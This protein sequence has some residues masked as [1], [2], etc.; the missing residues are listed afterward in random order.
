MANVKNTFLSAGVYT[1]EFDLSF[2]PDVIPAVGLAVVG[3]A[4]RGPGL[5]PTPV[6][7][8]SEYLRWF[9]DVF[10]SGS[11]DDKQE[12]K[13]LTTYAV[14]EYLRYGE[15]CTITRIMGNRF[16]PAKSY[17]LAQSGDSSSATAPAGQDKEDY[18]DDAI[19]Q[20]NAEET[21]TI[22]R[23]QY[24]SRLD[25]DPGNDAITEAEFKAINDIVDS[26]YNDA[27]DTA[28]NAVIPE[29]A[30]EL[31]TL[32]DGESSNS[33]TKVSAL[34]GQTSDYDAI[35]NPDG[36][37][38]DTD[39][40]RDGSRY[41]IRWEVANVD[42]K[43][44]TFDVYI[45]RGDDSSNRPIRLEAFTGVTLDPRQ[46]NYIEKVI[47]N[48]YYA[49][50]ADSSG[51]PYLQKVGTYANRSRFV[52]V[53]V[54]KK[55]INYLTNDGFVRDFNAVEKLP[56]AFTATYVGNL[57]LAGIIDYVANGG[58]LTTTP[59]TGTVD[60]TALT[61]AV[62]GTGT[63]FTTEFAVGNIVTIAGV[64]HEVTAIADDTNLTV[65]INPDATDETGE[66]IDLLT[67]TVVGESTDISLFDK[68]NDISDVIQH[69]FQGVFAFGSDGNTAHPRA[70]YENIWESNTQ[71]LN[72]SRADYGKTNYEDAID[73][74]SNKDQFD[75]DLMVMPGLMDLLPD[76]AKV[77]TRA[78]SMVEERGDA[79]FVIDPTPYG[80]GVGDA[81]RAAEGRNTNYAAMY[82]PWVQVT[83]PDIGDSK[84]VP[85][86]AQVTGVYS[87]NDLTAEKWFAPAGLNRG[88]LEMATQTERI[89]TANDRDN[90]YVKN[91][92]PIA[93]FPREGVVIWGQKTLQKKKSALDRINVRRLLIA[94]KRHVANTSKYLVFEQNTRETRTRFLNITRPWFENA[95]RKQGIYDF[96]IKIDLDN[97]G[98]EVVDRNEMRAQ[99]YLKPAKTA[100]FIIVDFMVLPTGAVF[101]VENSNESAG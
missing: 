99:I 62:V 61:G 34:K 14:Q 31:I 2:Q 54:H 16:G 42:P 18:I 45:R 80:K 59:M 44:G 36:D 9:G 50:R 55:T 7:T 37:L 27:W 76:H 57:N 25:D 91:V 56:K 32:S 96:R 30:F 78:I 98:A 3:P 5:V 51:V 6:S 4:V 40:L 97:N 77:I 29:M 20:Y 95:R 13:Y 81:Q 84:W 21:T 92:N 26:L 79:F 70:M 89:M 53:K 33:G 101:P 100:E 94:A 86:S 41:N 67:A 83:D 19:A 46:S 48:Q 35:T 49:L 22:T 47:G 64:V 28:F 23:I 11:A 60:L 75:F 69:K 17:V 39:I 24:D 58:S 88:G 87:F 8:Y 10:E 68:V 65:S 1:R 43:R 12:Y 72:L 52:R 71:G 73:M 85:P 93:T 66:A 38:T 63:A 82:Y 15:V 74:L 90:L